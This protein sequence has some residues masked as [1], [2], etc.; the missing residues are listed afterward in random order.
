MRD[1]CG[2]ISIFA[3]IDRIYI[4]I[5]KLEIKNRIHSLPIA[6]AMLL[7]AW[8]ASMAA[9]ADDES[10]EVRIAL[11]TGHVSAVTDYDVS[12]DGCFLASVDESHK[13][14]V[15]DLTTGHQMA[16]IHEFCPLEV[17][18]SKHSGVLIVK[19]NGKHYYDLA[20]MRRIYTVDEYSKDYDAP[21]EKRM[22]KGVTVEKHDNVL[23]VKKGL[24]TMV[25]DPKA[26]IPTFGFI[27][28]N[29]IN[30]RWWLCINQP[31]LW[32]LTT[33]KLNRV[34][35]DQQMKGRMFGDRYYNPLF[36]DGG[37]TMM[38]LDALTGLVVQNIALGGKGE[39]HYCEL[40]T[41]SRTLV[42]DRDYNLWQTDI[43]TGESR[44]FY[45][46]I[47][48]NELKGIFA[49]KNNDEVLVL[50]GNYSFPMLMNIHE[51]KMTMCGDIGEGTETLFQLNDSMYYVSGKTTAGLFYNKDLV[52]EYKVQELKESS[53]D[54][55]VLGVM[56]M[57]DDFMLCVGTED[58]FIDFYDNNSGVL[59]NSVKCHEGKINFMF[60]SHS[61][62]EM[63]TMSDDGTICLFDGV[64]KQVKA[65]IISMNNGE[66]YIIVTPDHYYMATKGAVDALHFVKGTKTFSFDQ[67]DLKYNRP[68][69]VLKRLGH[70]DDK[71]L[72]L[73]A[74]AY[75]KRLKRMNYSEDMLSADFHVPTIT[76]SNADE[77]TN[78]AAKHQTMHITMND[79]LYAL[80]QL[81]VTING[82]PVYGHAGRKLS[83]KG[84]EELDVELDLAK[85]RNIVNV[86]CMNDRGAE[87]YKET[88][89][90][91][92]ADDGRK[93]DLY[94]VCVGVSDYVNNRFNLN[95]ATK[96][97]HDVMESM[98]MVNRDSY[99]AVHRM[100]VTDG[101]VTKQCLEGIREFLSKAQRDDVVVLFYAGHGLVNENLD[102]FL[103][104]YDT[105]FSMPSARSIA[106][107]DFE[108]LLDGIQPL[109]KLLLIDACHSGEI[110]KEE[111]VLAQAQRKV[112]EP[113]VFRSLGTTI[114]TL[115]NVTSEQVN[116]MLAKMFTNL[117]RGVGATVIS[118][119]S[120]QEVAMEGDEW[121]NGLFS[122][123][124]MNAFSDGTADMDGDGNISVTE[125]QEYCQKQVLGLSNGKQRPTLR[126]ENHQQNFMIGKLK[127]E[128]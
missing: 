69:I 35:G 9:W 124:L 102:Y 67:F 58:G 55:S 105:D 23:V 82:V 30:T 73:Y 108:Q 64:E 31:M 61:A 34:I 29:S 83:G 21:E 15:W 52:V 39:L 19:G 24:R 22:P 4:M 36:W 91:N 86:S 103:A 94:I 126:R 65:R 8:T 38:R 93:S 70:A 120:G 17:Y 97:A 81:H 74:H 7:L 77:L 59:R 106:Y 101:D 116:I 68:D 89:E 121:R 25:L 80:S 127:I 84:H 44:C 53:E 54:N 57:D 66:D 110:D 60:P 40:L 88:I 122:Y 33:G 72:A 117:Q 12:A 1:N 20:T 62:R 76:V 46:N 98:E 45:D 118:S 42:Y 128:N 5:E 99:A 51:P 49:T 112:T 63:L 41:D 18:F 50:F 107:E 28:K 14:V 114:P 87:S 123:V 90:M 56:V 96:D 16:V 3:V 119:A 47:Q 75:A 78:S 27:Q 85:G 26:D 109:K 100:L 92:I 32:D 79:T 43:T 6:V 71:T 104:T 111:M 11:Q 113:I 2:K 115:N 37:D 48:G 13:V 10:Q 125:L 95:Y